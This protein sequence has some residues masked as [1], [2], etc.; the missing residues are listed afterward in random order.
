VTLDRAIWDLVHAHE[1]A[2]DRERPAEHD[3]DHNQDQDRDRPPG[4]G[5][6]RRDAMVRLL[7]AAVGVLE[8]TR[9]LIGVTEEVLKEQRD[10]VAAGLPSELDRR[11]A[12]SRDR[13]RRRIDLTF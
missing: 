8:S 9:H 3:R 13:P 7:D 5:D 1:T 4:P 12:P 2:D 6:T 11:V 10:R